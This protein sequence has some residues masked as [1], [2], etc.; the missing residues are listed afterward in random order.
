MILISVLYQN[1]SSSRIVEPSPQGFISSSINKLVT[2][3]FDWAYRRLGIVWS[4]GVGIINLDRRSC[5]GDRRGLR[6]RVRMVSRCRIN[7]S[8]RDNWWSWGRRRG[9]DISGRIYTW[10]SITQVVLDKVC[11]FTGRRNVPMHSVVDLTSC[12]IQYWN[13][14]S[15][16]SDNFDI[17]IVVFKAKFQKKLNGQTRFFQDR[18]NFV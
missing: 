3:T 17:L 9:H 18:A 2:C 16:T 1:A 10:F 5:S 15:Q 7:W 4:F 8:G 14:Q 12:F 13:R 11:L 6:G